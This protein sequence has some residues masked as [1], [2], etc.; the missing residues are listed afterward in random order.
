MFLLQVTQPSF[1]CSFISYLSFSQRSCSEPGGSCSRA[2]CA[3]ELSLQCAARCSCA[4]LLGLGR[5]KEHHLPPA[6]FLPPAWC[7]EQ[8]HFCS[9]QFVCRT[10]ISTYNLKNACLHSSL[11][12]PNEFSSANTIVHLQMNWKFLKIFP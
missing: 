3:G 10:N 8:L 9:S 4:S 6:R 12:C 2:V 11:A 7:L 1:L 5:R